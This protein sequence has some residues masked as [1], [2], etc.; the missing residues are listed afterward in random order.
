MTH[1]V[2][3]PD[4]G[5]TAAEGKIVQW[6]K[7]PGDKVAKGDA[8]FEVETDKVTMEVEAYKSGYLRAVLVEEGQMAGAMSPIAILTDELEEACEGLSGRVVDPRTDQNLSDGSATAAPESA[9]SSSA[10]RTA[11]S[12]VQ[13]EGFGRPAATPAAKAIA[14]E[15]RLNLR[16]V[17]G[18]GA[19]G[20]VTKRDVANHMEKQESLKPVSAMAAIT[21]RSAAVIPHFHVTVDVEV[22]NLLQWR[23]GWN[24]AHPG[25]H[26]SLNDVLVRAASLAL[27][28]VP[29]LNVR[30]LEGKVEERTAPDVL[31]VVETKSGLTL[32][33]ILDPASSGWEVYL[34]SIRRTLE[35]ARQNRITRSPLQTPVLAISNLGMFGVKQFNAILPPEC[36]AILAIGAVREEVI[37]KDKQLRMT[38]VCSL[39]LSSD[40]RVVDGVTAAR[41]LERVQTHLNSL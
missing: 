9:A 35:D 25:L 18:T 29:R 39:T 16:Q 1:H 31:L 5:Q 32:V 13:G 24:A 20:L 14:R 15:L 41:F 40:H 26:S 8:L 6:L 2:I 27:K 11:S 34:D 4:L 22:S 28:D 7:K 38:E 12:P 36:T 3:M 23:G 33:P 19:E 37:V 17:A 21:A 30:Y 10:V